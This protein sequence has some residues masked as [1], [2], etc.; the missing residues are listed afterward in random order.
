LL[1]PLGSVTW[2]TASGQPVAHTAYSLIGCPAVAAA[3]Y[4]LV[5]RDAKGRRKVLAVGRTRSRAPMLNLAR[6]RHDGARLG[7]N[8]V[9]VHGLA[10][11]DVARAGLERELAAAHLDGSPAGATCSH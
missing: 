3:T 11:T 7:A 1:A 10:A 9:H 5:R 8:E 6:I 2:R 4:L